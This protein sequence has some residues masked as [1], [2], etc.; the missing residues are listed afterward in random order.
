MSHLFRNKVR[1]EL[2]GPALA[3]EERL[4]KM[5]EA[6][7]DHKTESRVML[8]GFVKLGSFDSIP[9]LRTIFRCRP[10]S[11]SRYNDTISMR[12]DFGSNCCIF[13]SCLHYQVELNAGFPKLAAIHRDSR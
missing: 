8:T 1:R 3:V 7:S 6:I 5:L 2:K 12:L 4:A 9:H 13:L 10:C 11:S